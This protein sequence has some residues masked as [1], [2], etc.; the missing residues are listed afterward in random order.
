MGFPLQLVNL[1]TE[2]ICKGI[3]CPNESP[4]NWVLDPED[5]AEE[6]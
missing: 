6:K 1:T 4:L 5:G 2:E 3:T